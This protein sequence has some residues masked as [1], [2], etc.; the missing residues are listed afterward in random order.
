MEES[1]LAKN[2]FFY[3][4]IAIAVLV[5]FSG[6]FVTLMDLDAS[7][8]ATIAKTM[9][10]KNDFINL[11]CDGT[12]WLDKPHFPFWITAIFFK[13]FGFKTWAYKLPG[14]LFTLLGAFH[15]YLFAKKLY[16]KDI[17]LFAVLI[18][19]TAEHIVLS[20]NDVRAEPY[21][22]GL[23]IASVY[24]FYLAYKNQSFWNLLLASFFAGCAIMT[25]GIFAIIPI[26]GAIGGEMIIKKDWKNFFNVR[27]LIAAVLIFIFIT[28]ELYCLYQQFDLHPEKIVFGTTHV[29]GIKFF[30]WDSQF[31]RFVNTGPIKGKGD[32]FF[33][34]HTLL[35]AFLPWSILL[36][37]SFIAT[38]KNNF[39]KSFSQEWLCI[40]GALLTFIV[41]S[42]SKFQLP[43]YLNI[44]FPFFAIVVAQYF[45]KLKTNKTIYLVEH[46][47]AV[48]VVLLIAGVV[49]IRL[50]FNPQ[51]HLPIAIDIL[52]LL[53][54]VLIVLIGWDK[55]VSIKQ[56]TIFI[57]VL[58]SFFLNLY[59]NFSFYPSLVH[60]Q[61]GSEAAWWINQNNKNKLP[62][63]TTY[64]NYAFEFYL[65][66]PV[67]YIDTAKVFAKPFLT[68]T[69]DEQLPTLAAKNLYPNIIQ[70][71]D[72][73]PVTRMK[74]QFI[75]SKTRSNALKKAEVSLIEK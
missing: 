74:L 21:L 65:N 45:W 60:Y 47:Q 23:I 44:V 50:F 10:Q 15:T 1:V 30:F 41:F 34:F 11:Y 7:R 32:P 57:T 12:D 68:Y 17:A 13:L 46:V 31:G 48:N 26:A 16:S 3:L 35:W 70:Q 63:F 66:Q 55:K 36:Y 2:K 54:L 18:L 67:N 39:R 25:K 58:A 73:Y 72:D 5:N 24:H 38:I 64:H 19:L 4:L 61:S 33:F 71:F 40:C 53:F 20:D 8:Y 27:W 42:L 6:L 9:V 37:A 14:I 62:V 59:L 75:N 29:S 28:P 51:H 49:L 43:Y 69:K 56:R 22:T 52:L